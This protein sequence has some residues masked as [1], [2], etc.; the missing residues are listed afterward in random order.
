MTDIGGLR[1]PG[2]GASALSRFPSAVDVETGVPFRDPLAAPP[3]PEVSSQRGEP[4][5][6]DND[7]LDVGTGASEALKAPPSTFVIEPKRQFDLGG[8]PQAVVRS[9]DG[10]R[11][12]FAVRS[13][14][15]VVV[16]VDGD[17]R[18][19]IPGASPV[20]IALSPD[21]S[22]LLSVDEDG[23]ARLYD[24]DSGRS[25]GLLVEAGATAVT[26]SGTGTQAIVGTGLGEAQFYSTESLAT[27]APPLRLQQ[28]AITAL[29]VDFDRAFSPEGL[30]YSGGGDGTVSRAALRTPGSGRLDESRTPKVTSEKVFETAVCSL[31]VAGGLSGL[32]VAGSQAGEVR[33]SRAGLSFGEAV[34]LGEG[35][36][37]SV[38]ISPG[39]RRLAAVS[40]GRGY[41]IDPEDQ[42]SGA[43]ERD[44]EQGAV[45]VDD[46]RVV[47]GSGLF[48]SGETDS[49][50]PSPPAIPPES[51]SPGARASAFARPQRFLRDDVPP[52]VF[53]GFGLGPQDFPVF[54]NAPLGPAPRT[55]DRPESQALLVDSAPADVEALARAFDVD[56]SRIELD[57]RSG[58]VKAI[59]GESREDVLA[60]LGRVD[61]TRERTGGRQ[62]QLVAAV[63]AER[64]PETMVA[65]LRE[66]IARGESIGFNGRIDDAR[67][68]QRSASDDRDGSRVSHALK[69]GVAGAFLA[70]LM[71]DDRFRPLV[72]ELSREYPEALTLKG[73]SRETQ[74][75]LSY[76]L[77]QAL[78]RADTTPEVYG[79]FVD[80]LVDDAIARGDRLMT[81]IQRA[82]L[83]G[84][85]ARPYFPI[86]VG[87]SGPQG[88]T[89]CHEVRKASPGIGILGV[90]ASR[91]PGGGNFA[92]QGA[93][94]FVNSRTGERIEGKRAKFGTSRDLNPIS[95]PDSLDGGNRFNGADGLARAN[96]MNALTSGANWVFGQEILDVRDVRPFRERLGLSG[97][98]EVLLSDGSVIMT[99]E[100]VLAFG[101]GRE[102]FDFDDETVRLIRE[103]L[104]KENGQIDTV[105]S[106]LVK[107]MESD[108]GRDAY[109]NGTRTVV[110]GGADSSKTE[111]EYLG[112]FAPKQAYEGEGRIDTESRGPLGPMDWL[113]G[114]GGFETCDEYFEGVNGQ[115][116]RRPRYSNIEGL[117]NPGPTGTPPKIQ[118]IR[119]RLVKLRRKGEEIEATFERFDRER[120]SRGL[121]SKRYDRV[122]L[123]A[124]YRSVV[125]DLVARMLPDP[126]KSLRENC[127]EIRG[128]PEDF[129]DQS[130]V[131]G[132]KLRG[133]NVKILLPSIPIDPRSSNLTPDL[134]TAL[135]QDAANLVGLAVCTPRTATSAQQ[136]VRSLDGRPDSS[137]FL[138]S[139]AAATPGTLQASTVARS[140]YP[141]PQDAPSF[142]RVSTAVDSHRINAL[143][144]DAV[145]RC[146]LSIADTGPKATFS[147]AMRVVDDAS[148]VEVTVSGVSARA[149]ET[150]AA[151]LGENRWLT[152][153]LKARS[154]ASV[155]R[156]GRSRPLEIDHQIILKPRSQGGTVVY[157][158]ER[159]V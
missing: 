137:S 121:V 21:G 33:R 125:S 138:V 74:G 44:A 62:R 83:R 64:N 122:V 51:V 124:G 38:S 120:Q 144:R 82:Q 60:R 72:N 104:A 118:P 80:V 116:G 59:D 8:D 153:W 93:A 49:V 119:S 2:G 56:P 155:S 101:V 17:A 70:E 20:S 102:E 77:V 145:Q 37:A 68:T 134:A 76:K 152:T 11:L 96:A 25:L 81:E 90:E 142:R 63:D 14:G 18:R 6:S 129:G 26:F 29:A 87:G 65:E 7:R 107:A 12:A 52:D 4:F 92:G 136:S 127:E 94:F 84:A 95:G 61:V 31:A 69:R 23:R 158:V 133:T 28:S 27:V 114:R 47:L 34:S 132:Y 156:Q 15:V 39:G 19:L 88:T 151:A 135:K 13:R 67:A 53:G 157:R 22:K 91:V 79:Q 139:E 123:G 146:A 57:V 109:R 100:P 66:S 45:F 99:D 30:L 40:E 32:V 106:A 131:I 150:I 42:L 112:G 75:R 103:E 140:V 111:A 147:V 110:V 1:P 130:V 117:I 41:I 71:L 78:K 58:R 43:S 89:F 73:A 128:T 3:Q 108:T 24:A 115:P 46:Q 48:S 55:A 16:G 85:K 86:L 149:A 148:R 36:V 113:T 141:L 98:Y 35:P 143:I 9:A 126:T 105:R 97:D 159:S 154:N 50:V 54:A 5:S 10:E